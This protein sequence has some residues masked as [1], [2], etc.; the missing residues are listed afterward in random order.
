MTPARAV[1]IER[2]LG[3]EEVREGAHAAQPIADN[4]LAGHPR[5]TRVVLYRCREWRQSWIVYLTARSVADYPDKPTY[6][7]RLK[8]RAIIIKTLGQLGK[9][10]K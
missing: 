2:V 8:A 7:E 10:K 5:R 1:I 3:D 4:N 6:E 9:S